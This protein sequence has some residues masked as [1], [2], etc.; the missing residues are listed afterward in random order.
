VTEDTVLE[1]HLQSTHTPRNI[2]SVLP[3]AL[4]LPC[5]VRIVKYKVR[6]GLLDKSP[7]RSHSLNT[8]KMTDFIDIDKCT[9]YLSKRV[10]YLQSFNKAKFEQRQL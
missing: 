3:G 10:I 6:G 8:A 7:N 4:G 9:A 2:V 5:S 1:A